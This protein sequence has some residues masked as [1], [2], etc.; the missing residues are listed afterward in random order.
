VLTR[1]ARFAAALAAARRRAFQAAAAMLAALR[2]E[3][4]AGAEDPVVA[5]WSARVTAWLD[6]PPPAGW[7]GTTTL[8]EK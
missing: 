4:L 3:R 2:A 6:S 7:D 5:L 8:S 1:S